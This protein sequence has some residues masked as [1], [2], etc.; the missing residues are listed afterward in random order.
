MLGGDFYYIANSPWRVR[1]RWL[2]QGGVALCR[3]PRSGACRSRPRADA[4]RRTASREGRGAAARA[5]PIPAI[6][7]AYTAIPAPEVPEPQVLVRRVLV[8]VVVRDRQRHDRR[9]HH[10]L[11]HGER[12]APVERRHAT[13]RRAGRLF[14]QRVQLARDRDARAA[15]RWPA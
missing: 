15:M 7:A 8:V 11:E 2:T 13:H 9:V 10:F 3:A 1:R 6:T 4:G 14:E 12:E 5:P